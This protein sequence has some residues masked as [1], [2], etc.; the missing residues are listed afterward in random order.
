MNTQKVNTTD[1]ATTIIYT[2]LIRETWIYREAQRTLDHI[3]LKD[4]YLD[5]F[6]PDTYYDDCDIKE[7][8]DRIKQ[9]NL[10]L[11]K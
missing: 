1:H 7:V 8:H 5:L 9:P 2:R 10:R 4:L 3:E 11:I 6:E